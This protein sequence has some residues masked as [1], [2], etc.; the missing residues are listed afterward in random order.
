MGAAAARD[1]VLPGVDVAIT[2]PR[3]CMGMAG[4]APG[5]FIEPSAMAFDAAFEE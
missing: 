4:G 1:G 2:A 5:A 3:P